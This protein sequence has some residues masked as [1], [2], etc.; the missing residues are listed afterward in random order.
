MTTT[1]FIAAAL[2]ED[3]GAG[4]FSTLASIDKNAK[5]KAVLKV[6]QEGILAGVELAQQIFHYL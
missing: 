6:K 2:K 5:G 4:D 1:D 3:I